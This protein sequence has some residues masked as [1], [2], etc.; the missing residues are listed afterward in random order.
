MAQITDYPAFSSEE[1]VQFN[2]EAWTVKPGHTPKSGADRAESVRV[3]AYRLILYER[4]LS[5][6]TLVRPRVVAIASDG[7]VL[8]AGSEL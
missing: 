8:R 2:V 3:P 6:P 7:Q 5:E 1:I 4:P